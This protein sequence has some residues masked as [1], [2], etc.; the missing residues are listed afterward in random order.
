LLNLTRALALEWAPKVRVNHIT[1]GPIRTLAV[2][3]IYGPDAGAAVSGTIPMQR[4]A[5]PADV[6]AACLFL[7]SPVAGYVT[8]ADLPVHGGGELPARYFAMRPDQ[9]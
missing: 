6:A 5:E 7:T 2:A 3:G 8:G 1:V 9:D 4:L